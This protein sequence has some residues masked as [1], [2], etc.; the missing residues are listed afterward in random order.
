[1]PYHHAFAEVP[2]AYIDAA[3]IAEDRKGWLRPP[4]NYSASGCGRATISA[5]S[6]EANNKEIRSARHEQE[7]VLRVLQHRGRDLP[8]IERLAGRAADPHHDQIITPEARLSQN[9]VLGGD[10]DS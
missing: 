10:V 1:M 2:R 4:N 8:E 9:G 6:E 5:K 3:A 7:R